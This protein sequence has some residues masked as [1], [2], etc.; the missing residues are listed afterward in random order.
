MVRPFWLYSRRISQSSRRVCGSRPHARFV[1]KQNLRIVHHGA[2]DGHALHHAARKAAHQ[3][4]GPIRQL[5][6]VE[7][8]VGAFR[9]LVGAEA[10]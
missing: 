1:E 8:R 10:E 4:V 3:L 6:A 2:R 9:A 5:E 7:Q